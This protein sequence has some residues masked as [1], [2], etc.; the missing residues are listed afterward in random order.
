MEDAKVLTISELIRRSRPHTATSSQSRSFKPS[1]S[2]SRRNSPAGN[3]DS[4]PNP[5]I[6]TPLE[7]PAL[8]IG[9]VTLPTVAL[10]CP[11]KSCLQFSDDSSSV[12]CDILGRDFRVI[13]TKIR[14]LA[15]NFIPLKQFGGGFLEI[16][17]WAF[18]ESSGGTSPRSSLI[19]SFP[20]V[21]S[22]S[23]CKTQNL[24][25]RYRVHGVLESLSPV[26]VVPCSDKSSD[27][28]NSTNLRGFLVKVLACECKLCRS[29]E[30]VMVLNRRQDCHFFSK[31]VFVYFCGPAWC[32]YPVIVKLIGNVVTL[33]S[34]KKK[35]L[36]IGGQESELMFVTA[37]ESVLNLPRMINKSVP[38]AR[39]VVKGNGEC[40]AY[41][42]VVNGVYMQGT[43]V[44]LD[45][46]VWLLL[47]DQQLTPPHALRV[48]AVI[49]VRNVHFVNPKFSWTKMLILGS[50]FKTSIIVESFSPL[51]TGCLTVSQSQSLLGKF[52]ES[53]AFSTR[54][55]ALLIISCFRKM[56]SGMLS[57]KEILGSKHNVGL[58]QKYSSLHLPSSTFQARNGVFREFYKHESSSCQSQPNAGNL[59]LVV[60]IS[61]FI[62]HCEAMWVKALLQSEDTSPV[63]CQGKSYKR[64]KRITFQSEDIS[65][66]LVGSL[67]VSPSSGRLQLVDVTGSIDV[68]IPDLPST[69]NPNSIFEIVDYGLI[70]EGIPEP[71]NSSK[72]IQNKSFSCRSIFHYL[73]LARGRNL[74]IFLYFH[75]SN[76]TSRNLPLYPSVDCKANF[77]EIEKGTFHLIRIT[78]KFPLLQ[79]FKGDLAISKRSSM[80]VEAIVLPWYLF[81][82]AREKNIYP[83]KVSRDKLNCVSENCQSPHKRHKIDHASSRVLDP[84]L[85]DNFGAAGNK[86]RNCTYEEAGEEQRCLN[87]SFSDEIPCVATIRGVKDYSLVCSGILYCTKAN[88]KIDVNCNS[89]VKVL[90]ELN[91]ESSFNYQLLQI[92]GYFMIKHNIEDP[93]CNVKDSDRIPGV[94]IIMTSTTPMWSISF[95]SEVP[96]S[97]KS[98]H[99]PSFQDSLLSNDFVLP[100][101][102]TELQLKASGDSS[103]PFSDVCLYVSRDVIGHLKELEESLIR[104]ATSLEETSK[105]STC[106]CTMATASLLSSGPGSNCLFSGGNLISVCGDVIAVHTFDEGTADTYLSTEGSGDLSHFR[107]SHKSSTYCIHVSMAHQ[108]VRISGSLGKS[109]YPTGFGPGINATFHRIIE[110]GAPDKLMLTPVSFI[111][112]NSMRVGS[113]PYSKICSNLWPTNMYNV[114]T[115]NLVSSGLICQLVQHSSGNQ[116]HLRCRVVAVHMLVLEKMNGKYN[117]LQSRTHFRPL[118]VNIPIAGFVLDDGSCCC[119]CWANAAR[120]AT[121]LRLHEELPEIALENI[122]CKAKP[123][124]CNNSWSSSMYHLERI[125]QKH[126][127]ITVRNYGS[128]VDSSYQDLVISASSDDVLTCS[129]ENF[130]KFIMLNACFSTVWTVVGGLMDPGVVSFLEKELQVEKDMTIPSMPNIYAREVC[131]VN[132][133]SEVRDIIRELI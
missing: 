69:W 66:T 28:S 128:M 103:I 5:K 45:K 44:E 119:C 99:D 17:E 75:L 133:L 67:K 93:F 107:F 50:C 73:P 54:L 25:S 112:I 26:S 78:H 131:Y 70:V 83:D 11:N 32:W 3:V 21:S 46:E 41:T 126:G 105:L 6:L 38:L 1:S 13:G 51:E 125:L 29:E 72:L 89:N 80:F 76:A 53:L 62:H 102:Q 58:V 92:G 30:C 132:L 15:W 59:K 117:E 49:S 36:F 91:N 110:M 88:I 10:K 27:S 106:S 87:S 7:H 18:L 85:T 79:K 123:S 95:S 121:L 2:G 9:T 63:L 109:R 118:H 120:A 47:T 20:L 52:I 90:L 129:D 127:R 22:S 57:E 124:Q 82:D 35:L 40:G 98:I 101:D 48:G 77:K 16:I 23:E 81:L 104:P 94:K 42:G 97:D 12:C 39:N 115:E 4:N 113:E 122:G 8:L 130:L 60:P 14:V 31:P 43:V 100:S 84:S 24:K 19:D 61:T 68:I 96:P 114:A 65:I 86:M 55:W 116:N 71:V 56:F 64:L 108:T 33:S 74:A 34:L 111:E 37:E